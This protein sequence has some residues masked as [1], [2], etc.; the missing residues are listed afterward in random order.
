M[1]R[2]W[3]VMDHGRALPQRYFLIFLN[4]FYDEISRRSWEARTGTLCVPRFVRAMGGRIEVHTGRRRIN[5]Y[6]DTSSECLEDGVGQQGTGPRRK[7]QEDDD[8]AK[9]HSHC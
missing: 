8:Y 6:G 3:S 9:T 7:E 1:T 2:H 4:H 5:I